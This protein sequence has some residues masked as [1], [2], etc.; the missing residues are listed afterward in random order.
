VERLVWLKLSGNARL[1][2]G[3]AVTTA[4]CLLQC[5]KSVPVYVT[6]TKRSFQRG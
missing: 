3:Q 6:V 1:A 2:P 5:G 4:C